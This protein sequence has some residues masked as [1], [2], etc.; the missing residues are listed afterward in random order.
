VTVLGANLGLPGDDVFYF[1][2]ATAEAGDSPSNTRVTAT[3][4]LLARNNPR[5]FLNPAQITLNFDYNRD[6]RINA[7]DVLLARNNQTNFLTALKL[8]DLSALG[9]DGSTAADA[10]AHDPS[11]ASVQAYWDQV[12]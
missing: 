2:S 1:G 3:D 10:E 8:L 6:Q 7:T 4:L 9:Q 5:S 12:L 11:Q